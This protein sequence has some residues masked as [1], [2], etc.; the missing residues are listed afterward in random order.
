MPWTAEL[1]KILIID[2]SL[3]DFNHGKCIMDWSF[4]NY[5]ALTVLLLYMTQNS[6]Q[7]SLQSRKDSLLFTMYYLAWTY[8]DWWGTN[9]SIL[10]HLSMFCKVLFMGDNDAYNVS[11]KSD[12]SSDLMRPSSSWGIRELENLKPK[13]LEPKLVIHTNLG[14]H[15]FIIF[16]WTS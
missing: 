1:N 5:Y 8:L 2:F 4:S 16:L 9:W 12:S 13:F 14:I 6:S 11:A 10:F 15:A 3:Y 7:I